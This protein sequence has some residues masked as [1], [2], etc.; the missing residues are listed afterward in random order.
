[1]KFRFSHLSEK[2]IVLALHY[3][4]SYQLTCIILRQTIIDRILANS[5]LLEENEIGMPNLLKAVDCCPILQKLSLGQLESVWEWPSLNQRQIILDRKL[6]CITSN[7]FKLSNTCS[8]PLAP[9]MTELVWGWTA[10]PAR[11]KWLTLQPSSL[12][13]ISDSALEW[14]ASYPFLQTRSRHQFS[15]ILPF[16]WRI[17]CLGVIESVKLTSPCSGLLLLLSWR[18]GRND[19]RIDCFQERLYCTFRSVNQRLAHCSHVGPSMT[20]LKARTT[21]SFYS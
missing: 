4:L 17:N 21:S 11:A 6:R 3:S 20:K 9:R 8:R 19:L 15:Q 18:E 7:T 16:H 2:L 10:T 1:M 5:S 14:S 12:W 13:R